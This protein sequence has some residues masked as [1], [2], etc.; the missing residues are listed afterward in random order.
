[1][2]VCMYAC[3]MALV[4]CVGWLC[5]DDDAIMVLVCGINVDDDEEEDGVMSCCCMMLCLWVHTC[6]VCIH[7]RH[8]C[9][10]P[11]TLYTHTHTHTHIQSLVSHTPHPSSMH[12]PHTCAHPSHT[13]TSLTHAHIPHTRPHPSHTHHIPHTHTTSLTHTPH[14][15]HT[16]RPTGRDAVM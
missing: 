16:H 14:P 9:S 13:P 7:A 11:Q 10:T 1:M 15:S 12:I 6:T 5:G 2:C 4:W 3:R 8:T